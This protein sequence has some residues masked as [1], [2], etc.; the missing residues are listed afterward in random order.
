MTG[1]GRR[2]ASLRMLK[3]RGRP[4]IVLAGRP[5]AFLGGAGERVANLDVAHLFSIPCVITARILQ[6]FHWEKPCESV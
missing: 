4:A 5:K 3:H 1:G 6:F 2:G